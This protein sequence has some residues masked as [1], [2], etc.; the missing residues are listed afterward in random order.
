LRSKGK[1]E[2]VDET[3]VLAVAARA[4]RQILVDYARQRQTNKRGR[5]AQRLSIQCATD[6]P[7]SPDYRLFDVLVVDAALTR[8]AAWDPLQTN[9]VD[10]RFFA[11]L[12]IEETAAAL[13]ISPATVNREWATARAWLARQVM[14]A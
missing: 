6:E 14:R 5:S 11:G 2:W 4:M 12:T 7:A 9:V 13:N 10:L 3:H 1:N 8:L